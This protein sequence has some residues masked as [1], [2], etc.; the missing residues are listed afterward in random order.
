MA[1]N[2]AVTTLEIKGTEKVA[3]TMKELKAQIQAYRDELVALGQVED[4]N[5]AQM[6]EQ[7]R[8]TEKLQ[9]A[10]Q[11]LSDV[12]NAHKKVL[13]ENERAIDASI[14]SY[15][16]LQAEM[17]KLKKAY[18]DMTAA[19]RESDFGRQTLNS[20]SALDSKLKVIDSE[21]GQ[22]QR[23]VGNYGRTF[24]ESMQNVRQSSGYAAQ[25]LGTLS[26][27][28]ALAGVQ[29]EGL[30]KTIA[31]VTLAMQVMQNEGVTKL[32]VKLKELIASKIAAKAA[33]EAQSVESEATATAMEEEA[34]AT[35]TATAATNKFK[36]ALIG[37]G[38]GA[39]VA[40]IGALIAN[41]EKVSKALGFAT[42]K[43][44]ELNNAMKEG[45][46]SAAKGVVELNLYQKVATDVTRAEKERDL[47]ARS[48]LET[49]GE[50]INETTILAAKNGEYASKVD[51]VTESLVRQAKAEAALELIK[52]KQA[53]ILKQQVSVSSRASE[54]P[55]FWDRLQQAS[56]QSVG[57]DVSLE[58]FQQAGVER[59]EN[60]LDKLKADFNVWLDALLQ[61]FTLEDF[62]LG[63]DTKDIVKS[64]TDAGKQALTEVEK[65]LE[66]LIA[67]EFADEA[68][69]VAAEEAYT[70]TALKA[71]DDE[72]KAKEW[73]A[74][75]ERQLQAE[76][77][78]ALHDEVVAYAAAK[79]EEM[80]QA[81][82]QAALEERLLQEKK[83]RTQ[84]SIAV[85]SNAL[86]GMGSMLGAV[87]DAVEATSENE[88]KA[89][90][91]T[92]GLRIAGA[93]MDMLGGIASA[94]ATAMTLGPILG[95]I[96]GSINAATVL[97][98]GVANIAKIRSTKISSSPSVSSSSAQVSAP[99]VATQLDS[100]RNI[101]TASEEERLN[102][103]AESQK[104]YILQSDIEAAGSQSKA[105]IEE[106]SF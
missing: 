104:V 31:G 61:Q 35:T 52:E 87:A 56:A 69:A 37:I 10:T 64:A 19:E 15:N 95:P 91:E 59:Q 86:A 102:R 83:Q 50:T 97:A 89:V 100:V 90:E 94:V 96:M 34:V 18:K 7:V 9:K 62:G 73:Q 79:Q 29:N 55:T 26:G 82:A 68:A 46:T 1:E 74:E 57:V 45:V 36:K 54:G 14:D 22:Y 33:G 5:E 48:L 78:Q 27:I 51:E 65:Q 8:V 17:S 43:Q 20:I 70:E 81:E 85:T 101:T 21:M 12:T 99:N 47:A 106:S 42:S 3:T 2:V 4:K 92:K 28:I 88:Q 75:R 24:E 23:N 39:V 98:T 38:I 103:M 32:L 67:N 72:I 11:L 93:T 49:L 66:V 63:K 60:K 25:G 6:Q 76:K 84:E 16:A 44:K 30:A 13:T 53:E 58:E 71:I 41:W 77:D 80:L 40:A 105:Q